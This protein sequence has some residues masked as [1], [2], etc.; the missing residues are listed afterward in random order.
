MNRRSVFGVVAAAALAAASV[1]SADTITFEELGAQ[2]CFFNATQPLSNEYSS[3]GVLF[4]GPGQGLGGAILDQCSNF[5]VNARSGTNFLA[6]NTAT[7][8]RTPETIRFTSGAGRVEIY[9][10][11]GSQSGQVTM[12]AFDSGNNMVDS[13]TQSLVS[14]NYIRLEVNGNISYVVVTTTSSW[15]LLEDLTWDASGR[16]SLS[17]SGQCPGTVTLRWSGATPNRQQGIVFGNSQGS[18]TIPG[19]VCQGTVLGIQGQVRLIN[20]IGT[21]SG[22]GSTSGPAGTSA[23]RRYLQLVEA[24][25]CNTSNVAQIP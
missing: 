4:E 17:L 24:P 2:P 5:G 15:L 13:T 25:S 9:A 7:Y 12:N 21:G 11:P 23:C 22:S 19:G 18:T 14:G 6:F 10:S 16:Y 1:V 8:A 20:V 3:R